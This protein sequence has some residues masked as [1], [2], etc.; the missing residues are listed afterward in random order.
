[1]AL[2]VDLMTPVHYPIAH[3]LIGGLS[4]DSVVK[5]PEA[6]KAFPE[7][8]LVDFDSATK[9]ALGKTHPIHIECVWDSGRNFGSL[10]ERISDGD[11]SLKTSEVWVTLK[12]E[13]CFIDHRT[14]EINSSRE[15]VFDSLM[16]IASQR[17]L[18]IEI[19]EN[20][21]RILLCD[22]N[23]RFGNFWVEWRV[24]QIANLSYVSH[25]VFF[26]P[27][28][29]PGFLYWYLLYPF[30]FFSFRRMLHSISEKSQLTQS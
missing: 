4:A 5:H 26:S 8:K 27:H 25:T 1:M 29:L 7:V 6:L 14:T 13:G 2:G 18:Q 23:H 24:G 21:S 16:R 11:E 17:N 12:H 19:K 15:K 22:K 3:A 30:H 28:G 10:S 9:D 20:N